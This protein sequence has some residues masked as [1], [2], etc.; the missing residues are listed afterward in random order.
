MSLALAGRSTA[1]PAYKIVIKDLLLSVD[2]IEMAPGTLA[3]HNK[4]F[5]EGGLA[6]YPF[7]RSVIKTKQIPKGESYAKIDNLFMNEL[8]TSIIIAMVKSTAYNGNLYENPFFFEHFDVNYIALKINSEV[9]PAGGLTPD[10]REPNPLFMREYRRLFDHTGVGT[11]NI[12]NN[13]TPALFK[14]G[15]S[16]FPFDLTPDRCVGYHNHKKI[17]G[18]IDL[19]LKFEKALPVGVTC[20][21]FGSLDD[22]IELDAT[23][24][25]VFR[26]IVSI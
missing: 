25:V 12:T 2:K 21:A 23:R 20:L 26:S 14:S 9:V 5:S 10:F 4:I 24:N 11:G 13:I 1:T 3:K 18:N 6:I 15:L 8:P 7:S 22:L 19:E 17:T 16:L